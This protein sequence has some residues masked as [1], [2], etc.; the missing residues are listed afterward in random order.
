MP[1][2]NLIISLHG[3]GASQGIAIGKVYIFERGHIEVH[4]KRLPKSRIDAEVS[5]FKRAL[6]SARS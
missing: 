4:E 3:I 1:V 2:S 5:R 6:V